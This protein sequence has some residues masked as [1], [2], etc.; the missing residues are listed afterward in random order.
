MK[1]KD[2]INKVDK[3]KQFED[4]VSL[5]DFANSEFN[6]DINY[7][8]EQKRLTS[9]FIGSWY[10]TDSFVGYKVYFFDDEP[11]A[12][13]SQIGRKMDEEIEWISAESYN[14]VRDFIITFLE[15]KDPNITL[16]NLDEELGDSY[17]I[18]YNEQLFDYH[19]DI[20]LYN[21]I[22]VKIIEKHKGKKINKLKQYEP[23]LVKIKLP[24]SS[25][26]WLELNELDF[27]YNIINS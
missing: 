26:Q 18:S 25:E 8:E 24:D 11:V 6:L 3:S 10:C 16:C 4:G 7:Y 15:H 19:R 9:Y 5:Y 2:I 14:K 27:P 13:S 1:I 23:S 21:G 20:A 17:K 12:V 22:K